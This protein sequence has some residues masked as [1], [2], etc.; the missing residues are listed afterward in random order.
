M[1]EEVPPTWFADLPPTELFVTLRGLLGATKKI[2]GVHGAEESE[3]VP[4]PNFAASDD[5]TPRLQAAYGPTMDGREAEMAWMKPNSLLRPQLFI[6]G[7]AFIVSSHLFVLPG[8]L[9]DTSSKT[10]F[11]KNW[12]QA[13]LVSTNRMVSI[14]RKARMRSF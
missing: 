1:P 11:N 3:G 8:P 7:V 10:G 12:F 6:V 2:P 4:P 9:T 13:K 14:E 5:D